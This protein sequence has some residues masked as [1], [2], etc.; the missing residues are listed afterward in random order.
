MKAFIFAAVLLALSGLAQADD[1][2]V[3]LALNDVREIPGWT[4][5]TPRQRRA[6]RQEWQQATAERRREMEKAMRRWWHGMSEQQ[7]RAVRDR[8]R[9]LPAQRQRKLC[10][11][12]SRERGHAS[13]FC[14]RRMR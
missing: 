6:L 11:R 7:R 4:Q 13:P 9:R 5:L 8:W 1:G 3:Q 2:P 10:A 14:L 12:F